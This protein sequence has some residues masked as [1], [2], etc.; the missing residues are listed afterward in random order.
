MNS[1]K[2]KIAAGVMVAAVIITVGW[3]WLA[4]N[5]PSANLDA[6]AQCLAE[7]KITMYGAEWCPHCL[8]EKKAFGDSF[9]YIPYVECPQEPNKCLAAGIRG[10]PTWLMPDGRKLEGEQGI[11]RLSAESG[12]PLSK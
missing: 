8:N 5:G 2:S 6:F 7:K 11:N 3:F 12:C 9:K 10:Y 4:G 1:R